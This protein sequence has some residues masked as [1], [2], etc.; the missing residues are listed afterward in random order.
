MIE[1]I[2]FPWSPFCIVTR[3]ILEFSGAR[4]KI[5][6][7]PNGER[8]L[9]WKLTKGSSYGVPTIRD[10]REAI[11]ELS[12]DT[13]AIAKYIDAK[14]SLGLFPAELEGV[15]SILWRFIESEVEGVAFKLNDIYWKEFVPADDHLR[16]LRHKERKFGRGCIDQWRAMRP[17][18]LQQLE[19]KLLPFEEMLAYKPYLLDE[20]PRF[21]DFDLHGMLG[22]LLFTKHYRLPKAHN[23]IRDW[24]CRM[25]K[26]TLAQVQKKK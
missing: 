3:R 23:H 10:G 1:L 13:Q 26:I 8:S 16:F 18:L 24:Y 12:D 5:R 14:Y 25:E 15:Q 9:V 11:F 17:Q 7:I 2:Q 21:V 4:F 19:E 20:R 22:N 6:N